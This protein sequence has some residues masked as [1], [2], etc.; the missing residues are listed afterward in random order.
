MDW[1]DQL[2]RYFGTTNL[3]NVTLRATLQSGIEVDRCTNS[4][5][6]FAL[7]FPELRPSAT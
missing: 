6:F 4:P 2:G 5:R 1:N 3:G 7:A